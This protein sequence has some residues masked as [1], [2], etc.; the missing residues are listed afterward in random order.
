ML[1]CGVLTLIAAMAIV[2]WRWLRAIPRALLAVGGAVLLAAPVLALANGRSA[3]VS[4]AD[5][6]EQALHSWCGQR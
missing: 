1:C 6:I 2:L 4:R 3:S 5:V